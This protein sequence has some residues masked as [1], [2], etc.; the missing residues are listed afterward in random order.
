[1]FVIGQKQGSSE[2]NLTKW[3]KGFVTSQWADAQN[4]L[5]QDF[6]RIGVSKGLIF[7]F[8]TSLTF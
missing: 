2:K 4:F 6:L 7:F 8:M 3:N 5:F 1:M